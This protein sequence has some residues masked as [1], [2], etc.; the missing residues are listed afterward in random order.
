MSSAST[1]DIIEKLIGNLK[2]VSKSMEREKKSKTKT[3]QFWKQVPGSGKLS[4]LKKPKRRLTLD[5]KEQQLNM[6]HSSSFGK[7]WF[8]LF[9]DIFVHAGYASHIV[10]NLETLWIESHPA[11]HSRFLYIFFFK[12]FSTYL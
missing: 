9:N 11:S 7:H 1:C 4:V 5:S 10:H 2:N 12:M 6:A 8:L 3:V